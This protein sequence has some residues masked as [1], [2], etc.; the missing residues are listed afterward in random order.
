VILNKL[1]L[2]R[3]RIKRN[4]HSRSISSC[5]KLRFPADV[6]KYLKVSISLSKKHK[7]I[8]PY[9]PKSRFIEI[10]KSA[11]SR[12]SGLLSL[13]S[14]KCHSKNSKSDVQKHNF[15]STRVNIGE[16]LDEITHRP[17]LKLHRK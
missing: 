9:S 5:K 12:N 1:G 4:F 8:T 7:P 11:N 15:P 2:I 13:N 14:R 16:L 10:L 17:I 3:P 6:S